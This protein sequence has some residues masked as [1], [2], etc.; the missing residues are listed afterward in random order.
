MQWL[1][2]CQPLSH[3]TKRNAKKKKRIIDTLVNQII[4]IT[5]NDLRSQSKFSSVSFELNFQFQMSSGV[6][7]NCSATQSVIFRVL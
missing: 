6:G 1:L 2:K 7:Y 4:K 3:K 5:L